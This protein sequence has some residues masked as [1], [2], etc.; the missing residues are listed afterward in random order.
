M[1]ALPKRRAAATVLIRLAISDLEMLWA[2]DLMRLSP[3]DG[4]V[5]EKRPRALAN[6]G[7]ITH[8]VTTCSRLI[9]NRA[10]VAAA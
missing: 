7:V 5:A 9:F 8:G 4:V 10:P 3:L 1:Q 2:V 6:V